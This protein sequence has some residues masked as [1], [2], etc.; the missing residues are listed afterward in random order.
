MVEMKKGNKNVWDLPFGGDEFE[1]IDSDEY[2]ASVLYGNNDE[3]RLSRS[4][5]V[6]RKWC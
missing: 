1:I 3:P 5:A 2:I 4:S 6:N